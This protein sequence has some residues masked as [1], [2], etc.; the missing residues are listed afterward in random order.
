LIVAISFMVAGDVLPLIIVAGKA[1][2]ELLSL[3]ADALV[4]ARR[5]QN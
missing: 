3:G 4:A 2:T 1:A 5:T